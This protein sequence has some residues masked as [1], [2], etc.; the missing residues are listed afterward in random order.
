[1]NGGEDLQPLR[2]IL[3]RMLVRY[4]TV[5]PQGFVLKPGTL[6]VPHLDARILAFGG[7]RTL[8]RARRP[9]CRSLDG[10]RSVTHQD[11]VCADCQSR[12]HC[13]P[14]VRLDLI[15]DRKPYRLLLAYS[16]ARAFLAY[17]AELQRTNVTLEHVIH[18]LLVKDRGSWG[19]IVFTRPT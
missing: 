7:A 13:V 10:I 12:E 1:M 9:H 16:S 17:H 8:Y 14:Q 19:E 2:E 18:R 4:L 15:V 6:P 11:R 3:H 5:R